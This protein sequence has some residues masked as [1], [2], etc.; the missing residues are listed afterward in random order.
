V[1]PFFIR[2][3]WLKETDEQFQCAAGSFKIPKDDDV[4]SGQLLRDVK[5]HL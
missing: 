2:Y 5:E 3:S 4:Y 1:I